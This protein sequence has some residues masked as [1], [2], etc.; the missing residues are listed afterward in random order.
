M[1]KFVAVSLTS[2]LVAAV[3][4]AALAFHGAPG[5]VLFLKPTLAFY[6]VWLGAFLSS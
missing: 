3:T 5:W 4:G 6:S 1:E 2:T